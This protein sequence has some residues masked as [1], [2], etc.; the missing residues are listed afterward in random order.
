MSGSSVNMLH[1]PAQ[2]AYVPHST[3]SHVILHTT[4]SKSTFVTARSKESSYCFESAIDSLS[5]IQ[6]ADDMAGMYGEK[7]EYVGVD[8]VETVSEKAEVKAVEVEKKNSE[9]K[10]LERHEDAVVGGG[11][12][13]G[14]IVLRKESKGAVG[15]KMVEVDRRQNRFSL[16]ESESD[17]SESELETDTGAV[18]EEF[19]IDSNLDPV[20]NL[21]KKSQDS[22]DGGVNATKRISKKDDVKTKSVDNQLKTQNTGGRRNVIRGFS[23]RYEVLQPETSDEENESAGGNTLSIKSV[24]NERIAVKKQ[25]S[26]H[27]RKSNP[28]YHLEM[29]SDDSEDDDDGDDHAEKS[30]DFKSPKSS[31]AGAES[32]NKK[33]STRNKK[34]KLKR[35]NQRNG[36]KSISSASENAEHNTKTGSIDNKTAAGC[37]SLYKKFE[38]SK[39]IASTSSPSGIE[40]TDVPR[41]H[42][43]TTQSTPDT[44]SG[45]ITRNHV[46]VVDEAT[47]PIMHLEKDLRD[48]SGRGGNEISVDV[49]DVEIEEAEDMMDVVAEEFVEFLVSEATGTY[50][51]HSSLQHMQIKTQLTT[52]T[53]SQLSSDIS[54]PHSH[55]TKTL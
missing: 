40:I 44:V 9:G 43:N 31:A 32:K 52:A 46:D 37:D 38:M 25:N 35:R 7:V 19:V 27:L 8:M 55:C 54:Q 50:D 11:K 21:L 2:T 41:S 14:K 34:K 16:L 28:F 42:S 53:C 20:Q 47:G 6:S 13:G 48:E 17:G 18:V 33:N 39:L 1:I 10:K 5:G 45:I 12:T 49:G 30:R 26:I 15:K 23:N 24:I 22:C 29:D 3:D 4:G 36:K 51:E